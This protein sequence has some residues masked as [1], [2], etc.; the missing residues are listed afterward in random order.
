MTMRL[1]MTFAATAL[2]SAGAVAQEPA[3]GEPAT[4]AEA[5]LQSCAVRK[6]ETTVEVE[7]EGTK[8]GKKITLCGKEGQSDADWIVTLKDAANK[9]EADAGMAPAVRAQIVTAL[10]IEIAK[11]EAAK[12]A[13]AAAPAII[14][15]PMEQ[16]AAMAERS[17]YSVLP[18]IP[19]PPKAAKPNLKPTTLTAKTTP[20]MPVPAAKRPRLTIKCLAP[21]E[22]G[23]GSACV[24]LEREMLLA[25]HA[26][27]ALEDGASLR[28][29]RRGDAKG[30][31]VLAEMRQGQTI[32]SRLPAQLCAGVASSKVEIQVVG[33]GNQ[34]VD[35]LGP[36]QLRC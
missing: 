21:G 24:S 5:F 25:V 33:R 8:R 10:N 22:A 36:Y 34:I 35:R 6:F 13:A 7:V 32:R 2:A 9:V 1:A 3:K 20:D 14:S 30:E 29:L 23:G 18:A 26:D 27:E 15:A 28:F 31:I 16:A 19:D 17:G 11:V 12:P 4:Q